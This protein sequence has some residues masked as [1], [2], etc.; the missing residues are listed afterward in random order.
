MNHFNEELHFRTVTPKTSIEAEMLAAQTEAHARGQAYSQTPP[1][2]SDDAVKAISRAVFMMEMEQWHWNSTASSQNKR[3][4]HR[5][6]KNLLE[7]VPT[8][9]AMPMPVTPRQER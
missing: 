8:P 9:F 3:N 6:L 7:G 5:E 4:V 1:P 2:L